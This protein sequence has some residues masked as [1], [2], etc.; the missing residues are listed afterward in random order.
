MVKMTVYSKYIGVCF[1][2]LFMETPKL[3]RPLIDR[4][5]VLCGGL[6]LN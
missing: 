1:G 6:F 3:F 5:G 4:L 2:A